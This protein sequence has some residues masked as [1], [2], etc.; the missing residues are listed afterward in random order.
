MLDTHR[1]AR[2]ERMR[3]V[4]MKEGIQH[5]LDTFD[6]LNKVDA[7]AHLIKQIG[8]LEAEEFALDQKLEAPIIP[9]HTAGL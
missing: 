2:I 3:V 5:A 8:K 7:K 4:A 1:S 6:T 9:L